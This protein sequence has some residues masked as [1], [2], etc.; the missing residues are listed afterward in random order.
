MNLMEPFLF[1][2]MGLASWRGEKKIALIEA[3]NPGW[4]NLAEDWRE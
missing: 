3:M 2:R 4:K 1:T